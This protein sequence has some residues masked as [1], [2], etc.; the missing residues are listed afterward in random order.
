MYPRFVKN[1]PPPPLNNLPP[2]IS[3]DFTH[4]NNLPPPPRFLD[5]QN[6]CVNNLP[7]RRIKIPAREARR[8][9]KIGFRVYNKGKLRRRRKI[10]EPLL[11]WI[12]YPL[13]SLGFSGVN[14]L[15]PANS[16]SQ[17]RCVNNLP[18]GPILK[19]AG[20]SYLQHGGNSNWMPPHDAF[21]WPG[22]TDSCPKWTTHFPPY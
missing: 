19:G 8:E 5:F 2:P 22:F 18:P 20:G 21:C 9:K 12:T 16:E 17:K 15:T 3:G 11:V 6:S 7:P 10:L 13:D 1:Y 4:V 14:N